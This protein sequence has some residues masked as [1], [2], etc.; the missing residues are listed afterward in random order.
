VRGPIRLEAFLAN[1]P[2]FRGLDERELARLAAA[3]TRHTLARGA[4]LFGEGD[5]A[6]GLYAVVY[7]RIKLATHDAAG[8]ETRADLIGA[9]R[10]FGEAVMFLDRPYLVQATALGDAL[11]LHIA[12]EAIFDTLQRNP[13]FA[14][15]VIGTLAERLEWLV[16][17][18]NALAVGSAAQRFVAWLLRRPEVTANAER[19]VITLPATKRVLAARL[20]LSAEHLSR[21][22]REFTTRGLLAVR[23]REVT[24]V[25]VARLRA[26]EVEGTTAGG[27]AGFVEQQPPPASAPGDPP[28]RKA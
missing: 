21:V 26:W 22:L 10:T 7:G 2:L 19:A 13:Q 8:R 3:T 9:G 4:C 17:E 1:L 5:P 16:R 24:I 18:R 15:R 12:R 14:R 23:G 27:G 11:V 28:R 6:T 25:D 20:D